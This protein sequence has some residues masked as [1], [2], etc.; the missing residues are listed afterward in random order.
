M[1]FKL[2]INTQNK[3]LLLIK[4][5]FNPSLISAKKIGWLTVEMQV[6]LILVSKNYIKYIFKKFYE[7][8][9]VETEKKSQL[10]LIVGLKGS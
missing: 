5:M 7:Q 6:Q 3:L 9:L 4:R 2:F 10:V 8:L 1:L